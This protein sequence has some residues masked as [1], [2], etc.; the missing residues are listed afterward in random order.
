MA[1]PVPAVAVPNIATD[2]GVLF[3]AP[4]GTAEPTHAVTASVFSDSWPAGWLALGATDAG[5]NFKWKTSFDK[6]EVEEFLDPIKYVTTGREGSVAFALASI[7]M[8]NFKKALNGG[9]VTVTGATTTTMSMYTPPAAGAEVRCMIGWESQDS[10][11]RLICYQTINTGEVSINRKK[12]KD[13]AVLPVEFSLEIPSSGFP[14]KYG[15][16]GVGRA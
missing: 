13:K 15:T 6:I 14:F 4:L 2:P 8:A 9:T 10:T 12:G 1:L 16:A 5:S 7:N 3:W 11:E